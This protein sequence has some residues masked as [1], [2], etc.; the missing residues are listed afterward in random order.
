LQ[1]QPIEDSLPKNYPDS[2][3]RP[4]HTLGAGLEV[5]REA[6]QC[7]PSFGFHVPLEAASFFNVFNGR[8]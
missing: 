8:T 1:W 6:L 3:T 4:S 7:T 2:Q 5:E